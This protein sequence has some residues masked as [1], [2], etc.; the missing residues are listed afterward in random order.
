MHTLTPLP[1]IALAVAARAG[2][3]RDRPAAGN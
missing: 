3:R 1:V 2:S